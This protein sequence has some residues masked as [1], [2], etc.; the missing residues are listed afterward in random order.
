MPKRLPASRPLPGSLPAHNLYGTIRRRC[1]QVSLV[2]SLLALFVIH[3]VLSIVW[4]GTTT[5]EGH[6]PLA[7]P[8]W[9]A[10][11]RQRR[12]SSL[13]DGDDDDDDNVDDFAGDIYDLPPPAGTDAE[14]N[15]VLPNVLLI[16]GQKS[17]TTA[18]AEWLFRAHGVCGPRRFLG[19]PEHFAKEVQ[20]FDQWER[21][22]TGTRFWAT[23]FEHC[24]KRAR[25]AV[26]RGVADS[27]GSKTPLVMDATPNY[28]PFAERVRATYDICDTSLADELRIMVILR[29]P[30]AR[31]LSLYNHKANLYR[32]RDMKQE[33]YWRNVKTSKDGGLLSF[34]QF[35]NKTTLSRFEHKQCYKSD[36]S[37]MDCYGFYALHLLYWMKLFRHDQILILSYDELVQDPRTLIGRV[38]AFLGLN[39]GTGETLGTK[40][41]IPVKNTQSH[42]GKVML[43][44]CG[45]RDQLEMAF[46]SPNRA[47]YALLAKKKGPDMEQHPFPRFTEV[48]C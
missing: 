27:S 17:G 3:T 29:N 47:L 15:A 45:T 44:P 30:V 22:H 1:K 7:S 20:F 33:R 18:L 19:E 48:G 21:F 4:I 14:P 31:E 46:N 41:T 39:N 5:I 16:G 32:L 12:V 37:R 23:R 25:G 34:A 43:M 24:V 10:F 28:L 42:K 2:P 9:V 6:S 40:D 38:K 35:M 13:T 11:S 26:G 8:W 36:Y